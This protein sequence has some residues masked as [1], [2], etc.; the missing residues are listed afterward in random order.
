MSRRSGLVVVGSV[1]VVSVALAACKG[2]APAPGGRA[3]PASD[4]PA[5]PVAPAPSSAPDA[6]AVA[7]GKQ[8]TGELKRRLITRLTEAMQVGTP[9]AIEV[10]NTQAPEIAAAV[11]TGG[12]TV[13]RATRKPRNP[14]NL[15]DGWQAEALASFEA[16]VAAGD[17]LDG[18]SWSAAGPGGTTRYAEPL[19]I[20][21]VCTVCHGD[22]IASD[23]QAA[24]AAR[25]PDDQAT[26]YRVGELRGLVWAEVA[27]AP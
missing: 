5:A 17:G 25:Y 10:C 26:G 14:A 21:P 7:R 15:A 3:Q 12:V 9:E 1:V 24:L 8:A 4:A 22:A 23:V 11:S 2:D 19:V 16:R 6:A 20:Q 13:G 27:A 18:A